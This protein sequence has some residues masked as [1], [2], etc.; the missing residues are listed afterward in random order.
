[1][2]IKITLTCC[3]TGLSSIYI[4]ILFYPWVMQIHVLI[5]SLLEIRRYSKRMVICSSSS[6]NNNNNNN[7]NNNS[8]K[9]IGLF[10]HRVCKGWICRGKLLKNKRN[11]REW[12]KKLKTKTKP[13]KKKKKKNKKKKKKKRLFVKRMKRST[14]MNM[15]QTYTKEQS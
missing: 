3:R 12:I 4:Y 9:P 1:M 8:L 10:I 7:N 6:S 2:E 5:F 14:V 13:T 15:T 11:I